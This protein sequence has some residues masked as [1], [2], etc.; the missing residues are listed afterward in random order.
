MRGRAKLSTLELLGL[1]LFK[2]PSK[3]GCVGCHRFNDTATDPQLS[4]FTDYGYDAIAVPRN[5][6]L[7]RSR[8]PDLGLC[9]RTDRLTPST[10]RIN[11]VRFRTPSLRNVAARASYMHNGVFKSLRD[12]VAFYATRATDPM[13]WYKSSVKFE[14]VPAQYRDTVNVASR[15]RTT[16]APATCPPSTTKKSTRSSPS[17]KPSPTRHHPPAPTRLKPGCRAAA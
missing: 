13:R 7:P 4:L 2:D 9:E 11:C 6:D 5:S 14:D 3:G 16:D 10:D 8:K 12:V 17:C 1:K 15:S